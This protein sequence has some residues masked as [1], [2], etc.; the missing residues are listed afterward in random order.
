[1]A[2]TASSRQPVTTFKVQ[3]SGAPPDVSLLL[4]TQLETPTVWHL[5]GLEQR[6]QEPR[7]SP[8]PH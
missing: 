1:M 3:I 2:K 5:R 7:C 6:D 4:R 8:V